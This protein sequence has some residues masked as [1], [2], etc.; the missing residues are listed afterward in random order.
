LTRL[1]ICDAVNKEKGM[2]EYRWKITYNDEKI[3][4]M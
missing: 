1:I 3:F 4:V 2:S